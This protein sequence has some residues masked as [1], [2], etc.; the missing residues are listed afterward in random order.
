M[1][2]E[3]LLTRAEEKLS[4]AASYY[5]QHGADIHERGKQL[6]MYQTRAK[7]IVAEL[8]EELLKGYHAATLAKQDKPLANK[9]GGAK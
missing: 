7:A 9:L 8:A 1:T 3:E 2:R 4:G 5:L 6:I